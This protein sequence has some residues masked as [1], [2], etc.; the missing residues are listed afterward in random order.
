MQPHLVG[1][2]EVE[3][4]LHHLEIAVD[5]SAPIELPRRFVLHHAKPVNECARDDLLPDSRTLEE[6]RDH[7]VDLARCHRLHQI[8]ADVL[9]KRLGERSVLLAF[10]H[11]DDLEVG[12]DL[13]KFLQRS[14]PARSG[15]L[16]IQQHKVERT[17]PYELQGI[18][19]VR[20][21]LDFEPFVTQEDAVWLEQFRL[22]VYPEDGLDLV[23][24]GLET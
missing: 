17:A 11:H 19:G 20:G 18:V 3:V 14:K 10:R 16:L 4:P 8:A 13:A 7:C 1:R 12:L 24:H 22:V 5:P 6:P 2:G 23:R 15:H 9:P 21:G